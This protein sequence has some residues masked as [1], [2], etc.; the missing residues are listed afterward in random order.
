MTMMYFR[1]RLVGYVIAAAA[2]ANGGCAEPFPYTTTDQEAITQQLRSCLKDPASREPRNQYGVNCSAVAHFVADEHGHEE[3]DLE[4]CLRRV[5]PEEEQQ[6]VEQWRKE[7]NLYM[8]ECGLQL[9]GQPALGS[10]WV[11]ACTTD[12]ALAEVACSYGF[13]SVS[14]A[15]PDIPGF[16]SSF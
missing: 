16:I 5:L 4:A 15:V 12:P 3:N 13:G 6:A 14:V 11:E 2:I 10:Q 1:T 8:E 9:S 7:D